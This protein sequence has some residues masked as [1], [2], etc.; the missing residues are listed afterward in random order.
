ML[1]YEYEKYEGLA[2]KAKEVNS[3]SFQTSNCED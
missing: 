1:K 2:S 3:L